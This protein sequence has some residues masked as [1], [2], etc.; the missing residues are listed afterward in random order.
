[1][2]ARGREG[3]GAQSIEVDAVA[4][5]VRR[6]DVVEG[7]ARSRRARDVD[8]GPSRGGDVGRST[9]RYRH[10]PAVADAEG[11]RRSRR[12][13]QVEVGAG[14]VTEGRRAGGARHA[15]AARARARDPDVVEDAPRAHVGVRGI[16]ALSAGARDRDRPCRGEV[17]RSRVVQPHAGGAVGRHRE[18]REIEGAG[19]SVELESGLRARRPVVRDVHVV[20]R[21]AA[22]VT[23]APGDAA[24]RALRVEV[25]AAHLACVVE[26][27]HVGVRVGD[28]RA[29]AGAGRQEGLGAERAASVGIDHEALVLADQALTRVHG[30]AGA[31]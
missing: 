7:K 19:G 3:A 15:H 30:E 18:V 26:L 16:Q 28:R 11:G 21:A 12:R 9:A 6:V 14:T 27:D 20:D 24:A 8:R 10:R 2:A 29:G 31:V 25:E 23:R 22:S 1:V 17:D 5:A 4:R 13:R